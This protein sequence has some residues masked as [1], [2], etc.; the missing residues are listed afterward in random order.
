ML[1]I[2]ILSENQDVQQGLQARLKDMGYRVTGLGFSDGVVD[3]L[4]VDVPDLAL[5]DLTSASV[6]GLSLCRSLKKDEALNDTSLVVVADLD[7]VRELDFSLGIDDFVFIPANTAEI[8]FRIR[9]TLWRANKVDSEDTVKIGDLVIN[10]A[11]YQVSA[12][13]RAVELTYKEY[14]LLKFLATHRGRVYTRDVLLERVWEEEYFGGTRTVDV[15]VRRLRAKL[16]HP[17]CDLIE[18][19]RNV[20]YR[21]QA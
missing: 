8:A 21:F 17:I 10:L 15:H 7:A 20:G 19:V 18:T 4:A 9:H 14:E 16:P 2:C 12:M 13:G 5:V 1:R 3:S 11:N 6:D